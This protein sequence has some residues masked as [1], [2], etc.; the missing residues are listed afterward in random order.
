[1]PTEVK[2]TIVG[3]LVWGHPAKS[4]KKID[5]NT[6]QPILKDGVPIEQWAFGMAFDKTQFQQAIWP[7]MEAEAKTGYPQGCPPNFAWK[8][9]DGDGIDSNGKPF[10]AREGYAGC[11]VLN[12]TTEAFAPPIFVF[13]NGAYRQLGADDVKT[14]DYF[15]VDLNLKC[16][17]PTNRT[18]TPG[19]YV[20]PNGLLFFQ[21]G[22]EIFNGPDAETMFGGGVATGLALPPGAPTMQLPQTSMPNG[23]PAQ[24]PMG[25][26]PMQP[27]QQPM[28]Q[29]PMQPA[30]QPMGQP[31]MQP[32]QQPMGQ[33][34]QPPMQPGMT[35]PPA[36]GFVDASGQPAQQPMGQPGMMRPNG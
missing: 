6:K 2:G 31:P 22:P 19:L 36:A 13:E 24:Q 28:G 3:R 11:Y 21:P 23:A 16:N 9:N 12:I 35:P 30:Q 32:A 20:N 29:P 14:G 26:P 8:Y 15:A 25:Q 10:A 34:G 17:V 5:M 7:H 1:M 4:K 27:A 18:H 33:P